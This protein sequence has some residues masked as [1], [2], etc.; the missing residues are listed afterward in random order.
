[1]FYKK[2]QTP[3]LYDSSNYLYLRSL[4]PHKS[5]HWK[6]QTNDMK[7]IK[8]NIKSNLYDNQKGFCAYCGERL[9]S[10][11]A[12]AMSSSVIHREHIIDKSQHEEYTFYR[13][14]LVLSCALCND[15]KLKFG[16]DFL[17]KKG[18]NYKKSQFLIIHP[19]LDIPNEHLVFN[20]C[21]VSY[22]SCKGDET[23]KCFG[24]DKLDMTEKR[25]SKLLLLH[26][27]GEVNLTD[28]QLNTIINLR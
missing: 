27:R 1:M 5:S 26:N 9:F 13:L 11:K 20:G 18:S 25:A 22:L 23:I 8:A 4:K 7:T 15:K 12:E 21:L 6:R 16:K 14:N 28:E 19:Y 2:L 3:R 17:V 24:L 10:T